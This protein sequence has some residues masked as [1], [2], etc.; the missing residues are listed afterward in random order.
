M[1]T[2]HPGQPGMRV[3]GVGQAG[4][5][6]AGVPVIPQWFR[7]WGW[8]PLGTAFLVLSALI[9]DVGR[10]HGKGVGWFLFFLL[11]AV[12][13]RAVI[14][15]SAGS[16]VAAVRLARD[17]IGMRRRG[18]G[19]WLSQRRRHFLSPYACSSGPGHPLTSRRREE[20]I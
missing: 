19:N 5:A 18:C 11:T 1:T 10:A 13:Q 6:G 15:A 9:A 8:V 3:P 20:L 16:L 7:E 12:R 2:S 4:A 17:L 14:W